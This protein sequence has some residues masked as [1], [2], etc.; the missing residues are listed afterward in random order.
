MLGA[1]L[2]RPAA[3]GASLAT[4]VRAQDAMDPEEDTAQPSAVSALQQ[5]QREIS[6]AGAEAVSLRY[7]AL[8]GLPGARIS[9]REG[10]TFP[11]IPRP[12]VRPEDRGRSP[13]SGNPERFSCTSPPGCLPPR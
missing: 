8:P 13:S 11:L 9:L 4:P 3:V 12:Q 7:L 10:W 6:D 2:R 1:L 5:R